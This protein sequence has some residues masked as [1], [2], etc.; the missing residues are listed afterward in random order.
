[1]IKKSLI[2]GLAVLAVVLSIVSCRWFKENGDTHHSIE[3]ENYKL[4][5]HGQRLTTDAQVKEYPVDTCFKEFNDT[6]LLHNELCQV[7]RQ[8]EELSCGNLSF[9]LNPNLA[10]GEYVLDL[11]LIHK[12][13][14][15]H[16]ENASA[17]LANLRDWGYI[18]ID[19]IH[20]TNIF[21]ERKGNSSTDGLSSEDDYCYSI[22]SFNIYFSDAQLA[23][24]V[25]S[26]TLEEHLENDH[27]FTHKGI[28]NFLLKNGYDT[29]QRTGSTQV[30]SKVRQKYESW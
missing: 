4:S 21:V 22:A 24:S 5:V 29:I 25:G 13:G 27:F 16:K 6:I 17:A 3:T 9:M 12:P 28:F 14:S 26:A 19:T 7:T 18:T 10:K 30:Y 15:N 20:W 8:I 11:E 1:M 2:W 23:D